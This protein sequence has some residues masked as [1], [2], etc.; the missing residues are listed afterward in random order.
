MKITRRQFLGTTSTVAAG[1]A[2]FPGALLWGDESSTGMV[3]CQLTNK[4]RSQMMSY[5]VKSASG[6]L[7]VVD[8]GCSGDADHLL[9]MLEKLNGAPNP[10]IAGW[11]LS[12]CHADHIC[13][14]CELIHTKRLPE[15]ER[16][17]FN[18]PSLEWL[19]ENEAS[20]SRTTHTFHERIQAV[21]DVVVKTK[22]DQ[23]IVCDNI[24]VTILNDPH[25]EPR[26][27][28]INNSNV[29]FRFETPQTS[30]VFLGDLGAE[31]SE[32]LLEVQ[33]E[34]LLRA[35]AVQMAHHGQAGATRELYATI[36]PKICFWPTPTWL[37]NNDRG[38][39]VDS[40]PWTIR[41]EKR[42]MK[43]LSV[44]AHYIGKDGTQSVE[45]A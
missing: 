22:K 25:L 11:F 29:C 18:F 40:G 10:K 19:L 2:F 27:N 1:A 26:R 8:G 6:K 42:W 23:K 21:E 43:E 34:A 30:L 7:L 4:T 9:E 33:P 20:E 12:H 39:G 17:Y 28:S 31:G 36:A 5:I 16:I 13:A 44:E 35:D 45:F 37:W 41:N 24:V 3:V 14:L 15:V 32:K 38:Q